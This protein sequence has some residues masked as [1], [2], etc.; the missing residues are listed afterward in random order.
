[1]KKII[2]ALLLFGSYLPSTA[3]SNSD[4]NEI[5][6]VSYFG[7]Y[8]FHPGLK[9]GAQYSL[10]D[11]KKTKE[12]KEKTKIKNKSLFISPQV[13]FYVHP[14]N[15]SGLL[16]NADL[17]YQRKKE[18]SSFYSAWTIGL[19]YLTQ[20]NAG[21]TYVQEQNGSITAKKWASRMYFLPTLNYEI[22]QQLN[23]KIGWFG[24]ISAGAKLFYN[25]GISPEAFVE[26]GLK[27]NL[28]KF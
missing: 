7:H 22:G 13:G 21:I 19:G 11:W 2:L 12:R 8:G 1:M 27:M 20:F 28:S 14:G 3:Q 18:H 24:K 6:S 25:T 5:I 15:H 16:L 9:V 23:E 10:K 4:K 17:G 26:V